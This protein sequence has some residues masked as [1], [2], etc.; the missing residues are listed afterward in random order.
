MK[1]FEIIMAGVGGQGLLVGGL[2]LGQAASI[3]ENKFAVQVESYAPL[4]RGG[5]SSSELVIS[6]KEIDYPRV[7]KADLLIALASGSIENY[8][9]KVKEDGTILINS[10]YIKEYDKND[11][12][13]K[14]L[15][16]TDIAKEST[17]KPFTVSMTALGV[18]PNL[19]DTISLDAIIKSIEEKAPEGTASVNILA[20][21]AGFEA[22]ASLAVV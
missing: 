3:H 18:I 14:A 15:P 13:I 10:T 22:S 11:K 16:L 2:I 19:T 9:N 20:A 17:G 8:A 12:R 6:D 21:K 4:A 1:R 7:Q 5:S